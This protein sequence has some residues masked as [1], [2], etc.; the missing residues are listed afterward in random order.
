MQVMDP[1]MDQCCGLTGSQRTE[2]LVD[3][4]ISPEPLSLLRAVK[5]CQCLLIYEAAFLDGASLMESVNQCKLAWA[6]AWP[7]ME[8]RIKGIK[9]MG[10]VGMGEGMDMG[11]GMQGMKQGQEQG[12]GKGQEQ[13]QEQ[14]QTQGM[15][16]GQEQGM[17]QGKGEDMGQG[18]GV[19]E[20]MGMGMGMLGERAIL[21][22]CQSVVLCVKHQFTTVMAADIYEGEGAVRMCVF[23][24]V[25]VCSMYVCMYVY[26]CLYVCMCV[27]PSLYALCCMLKMRIK[28]THT[29]TNRILYNRIL[30]P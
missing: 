8:A 26:V 30:H 11:Q 23:V 12:Q 1:I 24:C 17:V 15:G 6:A 13:G 29:H 28:P 3:L 2:D 16:E 14:T 21:A 9:G 5:V 20:G 19:G 18:Q 22:Y 4:G 7:Q 27:P 10:N 25:C